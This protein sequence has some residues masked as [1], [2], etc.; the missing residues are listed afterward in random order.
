MKMKN[1]MM[2]RNMKGGRGKNV[3]AE[4]EDNNS[5]VCKIV[6]RGRSAKVPEGSAGKTNPHGRV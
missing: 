1:L 4:P 6:Q 2:R 5:P 3:K